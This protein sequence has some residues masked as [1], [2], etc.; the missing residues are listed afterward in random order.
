MIGDGEQAA[1]VSASLL[2]HASTRTLEGG[3][4]E[5]ASQVGS[6]AQFPQWEASSALG[7]CS[8]AKKNLS[9]SIF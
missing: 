3:D 6:H 1:E 9:T 2:S 7:K 5:S 4:F 8:L